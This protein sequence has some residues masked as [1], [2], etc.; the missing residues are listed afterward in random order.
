MKENRFNG[1]PTG[2]QTVETVSEFS[3]ALT[4]D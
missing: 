4:P 3:P 1:F 2:R